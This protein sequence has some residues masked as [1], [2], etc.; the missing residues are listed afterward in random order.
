MEVTKSGDPSSFDAKVPD[1]ISLKDATSQ[2][3]KGERQNVEKH[4]RLDS[5][6]VLDPTEAD[7]SA[8]ELESFDSY[9]TGWRLQVLNIGYA[10]HQG[11]LKCVCA[12]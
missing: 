3:M 7:E 6:Q 1:S 11:C 2:S 9:L 5:N 10:R 12:L 4:E 8:T